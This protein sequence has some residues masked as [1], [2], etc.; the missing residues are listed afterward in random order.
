[1]SSGYYGFTN[2]TLAS[3]FNN[4]YNSNSAVFVDANDPFSWSDAARFGC[5]VYGNG[6]DESDNCDASAAVSL[7]CKAH[8]TMTGNQEQTYIVDLYRW[9]PCGADNTE[10][11]ATATLNTIGSGLPVC[12][13]FTLNNADMRFDG[14]ESLFFSVRQTTPGSGSAQARVDLRWTG[15]AAT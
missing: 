13:N 11:V 3:F 8:L 10:L 2:V 15:E 7:L 6:K 9:D 5:T 14:T 4:T 1:M 12:E